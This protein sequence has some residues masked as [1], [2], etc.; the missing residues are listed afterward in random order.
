MF[1][2]KNLICV[3][4]YH[5][6]SHSCPFSLQSYASTCFKPVSHS[7]GGV[8]HGEC[9]SAPTTSLHISLKADLYSLCISGFTSVESERCFSLSISDT[10]TSALT[11]PS[12][13]S[14]APPRTARCNSR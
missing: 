6:L 7:S 8:T 4:H 2:N 1:L 9:Q 12:P 14:P 10:D 5:L 3:T 11:T 13:A